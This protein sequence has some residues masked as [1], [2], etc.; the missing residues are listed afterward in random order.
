MGSGQPCTSA[1]LAVLDGRS[2]PSLT[3]KVD[4]IVIGI[5]DAER[6]WRNVPLFD[7]PNDLFGRLLLSVYASASGISIV[8]FYIQS[9]RG[10]HP[11]IDTSIRNP[12]LSYSSAHSG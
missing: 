11:Y 6:Y 7:V 12:N 5:R 9:T 2:G 1:S 8:A 4:V 10:T 3:P